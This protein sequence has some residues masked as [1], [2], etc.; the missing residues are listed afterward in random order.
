MRRIFKLWGAVMAVT[1]LLSAIATTGLGLDLENSTSIDARAPTLSGCFGRNK[2]GKDQSWNL[3]KCTYKQFGNRD[4]I[5]LVG[6]ST[7]AS[8]ADGMI[9]AARELNFSLV[10]LPSS[11]YLFA[12]RQPYSYERC[13][14]FATDA[15]NLIGKIRPKILVVTAFLS[16]MDLDDRRV[17]LPDGS[18]PKSLEER[19]RA[20]MFAIEEQLVLVRESQPEIPVIVVGEIPTIQFA[21]PSLIFDQSVNRTVSRE[22]LGFKRQQEYLKRL[23]QMVLSI[24]GA[25]FLDVTE[26]FC[27]R[28]RCSAISM[29]GEMLYMDSYHLNP[30][31]SILLMPQLL[32]SLDDSI[33]PA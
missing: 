12:T 7:A 16:R 22:E 27:D 2:D 30:S 26:S 31:G 14:S 24:P 23:K 28:K 33:Q 4:T 25:R 32:S 10:V 15:Q 13:N 6:D 8:L 21:L 11:G 5:L 1:V 17:R 9:A 20:T 19:L 3:E 18:L 29:S